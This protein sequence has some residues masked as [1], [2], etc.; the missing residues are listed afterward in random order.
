MPPL[1]QYWGSHPTQNSNPLL[2][3][4]WLKLL[5]SYLARTIT[6]PIQTKAHKNLGEKGAWAYPN[7]LGTP[8]YL[9][10]GKVPIPNWSVNSDGQSEQNPIKTFIEKGS[11]AYFGIAQ[12]FG[13]LLLLLEWEKL[14]ISNFACTFVGLVG[15]KAH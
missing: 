15:T 3:L 2:C 7:V 1:P 14:Q 10:T 4:E 9:R 5:T 11:W 6:G 12:F 13:Y 8:Y